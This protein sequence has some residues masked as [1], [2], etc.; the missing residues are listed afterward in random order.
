VH[1]ENPGPANAAPGL[2]AQV[3][4]SGP[5]PRLVRAL[6]AVR[7][8]DWLALM[9]L[10]LHVALAFGIDAAISQAFLLFHFGCFLLWQP[11]WRGEQKV[12]LG[13]AALSVGAATVLV[14]SESWWLLAQWLCILFAL[15]GGEV[16]T[17]KNVG[18]RVVSLIA[19]GYLVSVLLVWVVPHLFAPTQFGAVFMLALRY[20]PMAALALIFLIKTEVRKPAAAYSVDLVYS[21]LLFLMIIVLVLGAFVMREV[22][23]GN[24]VVALAKALLI[25]GG[26]LVAVSWLWDPRAGFAGIGHLLTRYFL[27]VGMPFERWMHALANLAD[28]E[29]DP[30]RFVSIALEEMAAFPWI[31]GIDWQTAHARGMAGRLSRHGT[32]YTFG[33]LT[34]TL[35][36]RWSPSPALILHMRLLGRLLADYYETKRREQEQ[37][38]NAYLHAIYETGSRLTHDVKNLLQSLSS[39]CAVVESSDEGDAKAVRQLVQRQLPQVTQRLQGTLDKLN[40]GHNV[41]TETASAAEWWRTLQQRYSHEP[42]SFEPVALPAAAEIPA[43]LFDSVADNF[44]QNALAKRRSAPQT[45]IHVSLLWDSGCVLKVCDD[46]H[47]LGE[48][49][50]RRLF[51]AP[52]ASAHGFG[53]GLYQAARQAEANGHRLLLASNV[54][55][56]VCFELRR[57]AMAAFPRRPSGSGE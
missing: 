44:L 9:L 25:I 4:E 19:A 52:L 2:P 56:K 24:Y 43:D 12:Y 51:A 38:Q 33:V 22:S 42:V 49:L 37:R 34:M 23:H 17:I 8:Q 57:D 36:T 18:Q 45:Q 16:P 54:E 30:D 35:Y 11:V 53:V 3:N 1:D 40:Q 41:R 46:G 50:V 39:L 13:P 47:P 48:Y 27:S 28:R 5:P 55:G 21:L 31:E 32:P 10:G 29:R 26:I 6:L 20:G 7:Q 14:A 15:I